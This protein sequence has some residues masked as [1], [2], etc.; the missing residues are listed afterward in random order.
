[1]T[2]E[3]KD[4]WGWALVVLLVTAMAC[5][6]FLPGCS[7]FNS[8]FGE[9]VKHRVIGAESNVTDS[10]VDQKAG[11]TKANR[12]TTVKITSPAAVPVAN[13]TTHPA[14]VAIE[15]PVQVN[16]GDKS[17]TA[18]PGSSVEMTVNNETEA[19]PTRIEHN[20]IAIAKGASMQ[21]SEPS[22]GNFDASAPTVSLAGTKGQGGGGKASGGGVGFSWENILP[23]ASPLAFIIGI[24]GL[25]VMVLGGVV[26]FFKKTDIKSPLIIIGFGALIVGYAV[27]VDEYPWAFL[28]VAFVAAILWALWW[29]SRQEH[30]ALSEM[31]WGVETATPET[32]KEIKAKMKDSPR[33]AV[34]KKV[35]TNIKES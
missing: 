25:V 16:I 1:M 12:G 15:T 33:S 9:D 29:Y 20:R 17:I 4:A 23:D 26:W 22:T 34:I 3:R 35:V 14:P 28:L 13:P 11:E 24:T 5:L 7:G 32:Q 10:F 18:P 31:I 2:Q 19:V 30:T 27:I 6:L 8:A 21:S